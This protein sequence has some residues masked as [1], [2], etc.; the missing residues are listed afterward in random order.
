MA[1]DVDQNLGVIIFKGIVFTVLISG[2]SAFE[3]AWIF[4]IYS[5]RPFDLFLDTANLDT[6]DFINFDPNIFRALEHPSQSHQLDLLR[7][8]FQYI[9]EASTLKRVWPLSTD[10]IIART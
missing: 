8:R 7:M 4:D 1:P 6:E 9:E 5:E 2:L 10:M 3:I